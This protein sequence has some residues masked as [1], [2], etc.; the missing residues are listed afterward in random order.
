MKTDFFKDKVAIVT[1][2][3]QGIGK[4]IAIELLK[5][6]AKVVINGRDEY[7][8]L[9]TYMHLSHYGDN[10]QAVCADVTTNYGAAMLLA[11]TKYYFGQVDILINNAGLSMKGN[12]AELAPDVYKRIFDAN[13]LGSVYP[14]TS[15][16]PDLRENRGSV[17]FISSVAGIR[18][19]AG[20]SAYC[21]SKM[22]LRGIAESLRIEETQ[23]GV[24]VGLLY[25]GFTKNEDSKRTLNAAGEL[26]AVDDRTKFKQQ[27]QADVARAVLH[28]IEKRQFITTLSWLGKINRLMQ[29]ISPTLTE[30]ILKWT[31]TRN[32]KKPSDETN[33]FEHIKSLTMS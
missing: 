28:N 32:N 26:V 27:N 16:L 21:S 29:V 25:V 11:K 2:S 3:S 17:V 10:I 14:T 15:A 6:G 1:G 9:K 7:K 19:L 23:T 31:Y 4:A 13:I 33:A 8:L 30:K 5:R 22:A 20:H 18:G 24:H 12:L